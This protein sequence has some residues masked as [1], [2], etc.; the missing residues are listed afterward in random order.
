MRILQPDR[1]ALTSQG[2]YK[3]PAPAQINGIVS[4][5][6]TEICSTL[7]KTLIKIVL[8]YLAKLRRERGLP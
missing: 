3:M 8:L 1:G 6:K 2:N 5:G 7:V 4:I